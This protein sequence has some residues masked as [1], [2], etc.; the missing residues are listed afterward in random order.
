MIATIRRQHA[1]GSSLGEIART[2]NSDNV[3]TAQ[4]GRQWWPS[5]VRAVLNRPSPTKTAQAIPAS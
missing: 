4:S 5:T 3:R 2:L 1:A